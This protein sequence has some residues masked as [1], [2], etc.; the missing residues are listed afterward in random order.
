[1][2]VAYAGRTIRAQHDDWILT[3]RAGVFGLE[4]LDRLRRSTHGRDE[5]S[6]AVV[7]AWTQARKAVQLICDERPEFA[8]SL[9]ILEE[10]LD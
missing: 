1:M 3:M 2:A 6:A 8:Y 10:Y 7:A 9:G 4:R 5:A